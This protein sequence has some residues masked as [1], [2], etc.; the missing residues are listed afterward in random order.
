MERIIVLT[1][2]CRSCGWKLVRGEQELQLQMRANFHVCRSLHTVSLAG[3]QKDGHRQVCTW[4]SQYLGQQK[5]VFILPNAQVCV[6]HAW[7]LSRARHICVLDSL[8][9]RKQRTSRWPLKGTVWA[10]KALQGSETEMRMLLGGKK[11][12]NVFPMRSHWIA[13]HTSL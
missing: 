6:N 8:E 3:Y 1:V 11:D 10:Q 2:S 13:I 12:N 4:P 7:R 5:Q 9:W